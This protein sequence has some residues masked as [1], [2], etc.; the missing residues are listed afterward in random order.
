MT[1]PI[2]VRKFAKS[3]KEVPLSVIALESVPFKDKVNKPNRHTF[4]EVFLVAKGTAEHTID[5]QKQTVEPN[6]VFLVS[7]Y[8]VHFWEDTKELSGYAV[9]FEDGALLDPYAKKLLSEIYHYDKLVISNKE[10]MTELLALASVLATEMQAHRP[11]QKEACSLQLQLLLVALIRAKRQ[12]TNGSEIHSAEQGLALSFILLAS[13]HYIKHRKSSWYAEKLET[14]ASYLS[15]AVRVETGGTPGEY[16][17]SKVISEI[18]RL[19]LYT[20]SSVESIAR[21]LNFES[22]S[23]FSRFFRRETGQTPREF[24]RSMR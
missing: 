22:T 16:I 21:D 15:Q 24:V 1:L 10:Q 6:T 14:S 12:F 7:P 23:Y 4:Y 13:Q 2:P 3:D 8:Q 11:M 9:L 17:R 20:D 5:F 19:L 18:K